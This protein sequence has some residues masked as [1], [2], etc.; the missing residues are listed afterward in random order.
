MKTEWMGNYQMLLRS[1]YRAANAFSQ[2]CKVEFA[3]ETV[4]FSSYEAHIMEYILYYEN[5][6]MRWYAKQLGLSPS[7]YTKYIKRLSDKGLVDKY[8]IEGN[9]KDVVLRL[10]PLGL[11]E[12]DRY[13]RYIY[14]KAFRDLFSI[15]D[16]LSPESLATM[17]AFLT[18]WGDNQYKLLKTESQEDKKLIKIPLKKTVRE[19]T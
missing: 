5:R 19:E 12:Y 13:A 8:H 6:N 14:E 9:R 4:R 10:S 18:A 3:G 1:L 15:L 7:T 2:I 11:E 17:E 16:N